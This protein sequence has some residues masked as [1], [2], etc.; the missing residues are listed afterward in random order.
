[1]QTAN[2]SRPAKSLGNTPAVAIRHY[3]DVT[4]ADFER[5]AAGGASPGKKAAQILAQQVHAKARPPNCPRIKKPRLCGVS[6]HPAIPCTTGAWRRRESNPRPVAV[7]PKRLRAYPVDLNLAVEPPA[8]RVHLRPAQ[9][10]FDSS[11]A[12]R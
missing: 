4:D 11:R 10:K 1:M 5:A 7:Q 12:R 8:D 9:N 6:Q 3:V 2:C